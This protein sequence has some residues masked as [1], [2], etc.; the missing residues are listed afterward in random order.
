MK[1]LAH[2]KPVSQNLIKT[3]FR[4]TGGRGTSYHMDEGAATTVV[5]ALAHRGWVSII[6]C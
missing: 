2:L 3:G 4:L 1:N 5:A 6:L